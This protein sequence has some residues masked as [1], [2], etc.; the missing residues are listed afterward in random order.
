MAMTYQQFLAR[1]GETR[2]EWTLRLAADGK[3]TILRTKSTPQHCPLSRIGGT[4]SCGDF[5]EAAIR[6]NLSNVNPMDIVRAADDEM[7]PRSQEIRADMLAVLGLE[8]RGE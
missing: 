2:G 1:L 3:R 6:L 4:V 5:G 8:E 7:S